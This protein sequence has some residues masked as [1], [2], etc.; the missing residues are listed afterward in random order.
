M[1]GLGVNVIDKFS[2]YDRVLQRHLRVLM[3]RKEKPL[4]FKVFVF[5]VNLDVMRDA[6]GSNREAAHQIDHLRPGTEVGMHQKEDT[7]AIRLFAY[8]ETARKLWR[9]QRV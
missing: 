6:G 8:P 2:I 7:H 9:E 5:A 1:L 3:V 4:Q